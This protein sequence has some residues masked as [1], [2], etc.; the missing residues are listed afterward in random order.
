MFKKRAVRRLPNHYTE[1]LE[2][3]ESVQQVC[4]TLLEA[5]KHPP[6]DESNRHGIYTRVYHDWHGDDC[7][8]TIKMW[9]KLQQALRCT[10]HLHCSKAFSCFCTFATRS[11]GQ[12]I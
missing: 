5:T 3:L 9:K 2:S 8:A 12:E 6:R 7:H 1:S 11:C 4:Q 10:E